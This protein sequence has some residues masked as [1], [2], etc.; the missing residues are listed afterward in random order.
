ML[1]TKY[2][3]ISQYEKDQIVWMYLDGNSLKFIAT[4]M[5]LSKT[6][7]YNI[8]CEADSTKSKIF[9][10][11][12]LI[13]N[14]Y[15]RGLNLRP[16]ADLMRTRNKLDHNGIQLQDALAQSQAM[17]RMCYKY[18]VPGEGLVTLFKNFTK[19]T[20]S[21]PIEP[22][23]SLKKALEIWH[24]EAETLTP[25]INELTKKCRSL[26][27]AIDIMKRLANNSGMP[28]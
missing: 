4:S 13:V 26:S 2:R 22:S 28:H 20:Y 23:E 5:N 15:K 6:K 27:G 14:L 25:I 11:H 18:D 24:K 10:R 12:K 3:R 1:K 9:L 17:V 8:L 7:V 21:F 16:Y 19:F